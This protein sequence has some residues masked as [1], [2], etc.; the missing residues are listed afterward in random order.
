MVVA[1]FLVVSGMFSTTAFAQDA[2]V[3]SKTIGGVKVSYTNVL[4]YTDTRCGVNT[5]AHYKG[6]AAKSIDNMK[7]KWNIKNGAGRVLQ[8]SEISKKNIKT[9]SEKSKDRQP[10]TVSTGNFSFKKGGTTWSPT[11]RAYHCVRIKSLT[12]EDNKNDI[13]NLSDDEKNIVKLQ[14]IY[15]DIKT[16]K[17]AKISN[18]SHSDDSIKEI[19]TNELLDNATDLSVYQDESGK[20]I[21]LEDFE[22]VSVKAENDISPV[23]DDV[24]F[25]N[26]DGDNTTI[27]EVEVLKPVYEDGKEVKIT[28]YVVLIDKN[29]HN[30]ESGISVN[31]L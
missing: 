31:P 19:V 11:S 28:G 25:S 27:V 3:G 29:G 10:I 6:N 1:L 8:S 21:S 17:S 15:N 22:V 16:N 9:I 20:A 14:E 30:L 7:I 13:E 18:L 4:T 24:I 2:D 26:P 23:A 5:R 12:D